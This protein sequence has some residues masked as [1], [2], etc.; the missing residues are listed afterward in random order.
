MK[1]VVKAEP[2][3]ILLLAGRIDGEMKEILDFAAGL[4]IDKNII[5]AGWLSGE[6]LKAA[7]HAADAVAVPSI[8]FDSFPTMILEAMACKKPVIATSFGGSREMV[9]DGE[10]GYI[11]NPFDTENM[12]GKIADLLRNPEKA[13][14]F[15]EAG[16]ERVK[17]EFN[18][19]KTTNNYLDWFKNLK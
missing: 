13:L 10:T 1:N 19:E 8:C 3:A 14:T 6:E 16:Y 17:N 2:D 5:T 9:L 11:V 4:G 12:A 15:G 7:Y 18:L